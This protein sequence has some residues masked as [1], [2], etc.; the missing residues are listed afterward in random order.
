MISEGCGCCLPKPA[1]DKRW[2]TTVTPFWGSVS[3]HF[4]NVT[5]QIIFLQVCVYIVVWVSLCCRWQHWVTVKHAAVEPADHKARIIRKTPTDNAVRETST[6]RPLSWKNSG[7]P[8]KYIYNFKRIVHL[9]I[10][11]KTHISISWNQRN[12]ESQHIDSIS[13][14]VWCSKSQSNSNWHVII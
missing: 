2:T 3:R 7:L 10:N 9:K 11:N 8:S 13:P 12:T 5:N 6:V 4:D 1:P 14:D